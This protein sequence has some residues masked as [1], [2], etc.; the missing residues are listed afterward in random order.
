MNETD[1]SAFDARMQTDPLLSQQVKRFDLVRQLLA[2]KICNNTN[3]DELQ[4]QLFTHRNAWY[5]LKD[6]YSIPIRNYVIL[7]AIIAAAIAIVLYVSPWRKNIYRQFASTE[8]Q[9]PDID[10]LRLPEKAIMQFNHGN[11]DEAIVLLNDALAANPRNYYA[12][13]YRGVAMID[14]NQLK[15]A[16]EDLLTVF[17]NS[18][19]LHYEAAFYLALS[20]LKE[21]RKQQCL[22]WLLK[23]PPGA[24]NYLKVKKLI[25]E[26]K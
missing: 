10:S 11:F 4:H 12:R 26:L 9:I 3:R 20:Y 7:T 17:N 25:E 16:R 22:E 8:M 13:Y 23:I 1:R 6:N 5:S 2:Q 15:G 18:G 14:Q 24:P 19:D 21:G